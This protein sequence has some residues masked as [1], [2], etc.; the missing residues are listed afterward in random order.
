MSYAQPDLDYHSN[1][2]PSRYECI[3]ERKHL[4]LLN[5]LNIGYEIDINAQTAKLVSIVEEYSFPEC[6]LIRSSDSC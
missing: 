6:M 4:S 3:E 5:L 2:S 1:P